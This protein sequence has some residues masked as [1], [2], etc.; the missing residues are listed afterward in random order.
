MSLDLKTIRE[1]INNPQPAANTKKCENF[2]DLIDKIKQNI[3]TKINNGDSSGAKTEIEV[4]EKLIKTNNLIKTEKP[5]SFEDKQKMRDDL[6]NEL[7]DRLERIA[8][9][10]DFENFE[11][12]NSKT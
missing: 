8:E 11:K 12:L 9:A 2:D 7:M 1:N 4:L 5:V 3:I 6:Y 10:Q